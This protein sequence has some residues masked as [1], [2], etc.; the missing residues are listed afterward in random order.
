[1]PCT[2]IAELDTLVVH[3]PYAVAEPMLQIMEPHGWDAEAHGGAHPTLIQAPYGRSRNLPRPVMYGLACAEHLVMLAR[4]RLGGICNGLR[5]AD[6]ASVIYD[7]TGIV[8]AG[9]DIF[10]GNKGCC[11]VWVRSEHE[12]DTIRAAM[13]HRVWMAPPSTGFALRAKNDVGAAY[14]QDEVHRAVQK[15]GE[16]FPRHLVTVERYVVYN[17]K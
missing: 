12:V 15:R 8:V 10:T 13:H 1:M 16:H 17:R 14:L 11:S 9:V 3:N 6:I 2:F 5:P 4:L 7:F